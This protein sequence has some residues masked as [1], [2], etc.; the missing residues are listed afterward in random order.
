M[1][2]YKKAQEDEQNPYGSFAGKIFFHGT[3][4]EGAASIRNGGIDN[5]RSNKGYFGVGFYMAEDFDLAKSNYA[6]FADDDAEGVVL[7]FAIKPEARILDLRK[8]EDF[9]VYQAI[10]QQGRLVSRDD[11]DTVM[12]SNGIDGLYDN[13]FGGIVIYNPNSVYLVNR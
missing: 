2:W 1:N 3:S 4:E 9:D 6:D 10:S 11:F 12:T 7:G 5:S 13:S 8:P